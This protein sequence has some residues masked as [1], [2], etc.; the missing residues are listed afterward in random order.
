MDYNK[1]VRERYCLDA[2]E[3]KKNFVEERKFLVIDIVLFT[4]MSQKSDLL[5]NS[6]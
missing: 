5:P 4:Y 2:P 3:K 1:Y 6:A